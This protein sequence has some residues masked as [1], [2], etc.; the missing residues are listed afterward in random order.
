MED[1]ILTGFYDF[2]KMKME[3]C[4]EP[5]IIMSWYIPVSLLAANHS[6]RSYKVSIGVEYNF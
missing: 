3:R 6:V 2:G 1:V 5:I 4:R